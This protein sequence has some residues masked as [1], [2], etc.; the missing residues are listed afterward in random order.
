MARHI[1]YR[2]DG[3]GNTEECETQRIDANGTDGKNM[4]IADRLKTWRTE[5][6][7]SIRALAGISG[8]SA[9]MISKIE[10]GKVSPS[11]ATLSKLVEA[12]NAGLHEFFGGAGRADASE[13]I[14][15]KHSDMVVAS[16]NDRLW[17]F[18]FPQHPAIK[19]QLT[20]EEYQPRT[21]VLEK[22][23]HRGD[24]LG[25]VIEGELTLD[26]S[27]VGIRRVPAGDAFYV[28]AGQAHTA[29]NEGDEVL[30]LVA[31]QMR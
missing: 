22:E 30:R 14:V 27:G 12:M 8:V 6:E 18:A 3:A 25:Y 29:R 31:V 26:V 13:L 1:V 11:V 28:K 7:H 21:R 4:V 15:F 2:P 19:A 24:V 17:K 10:A 5:R 20:Y 9:S 16:D 23:T